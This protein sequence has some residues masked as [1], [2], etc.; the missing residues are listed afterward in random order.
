[1]VAT[2]CM[3]DQNWQSAVNLLSTIAGSS[4]ASAGMP[5]GSLADL[6]KLSGP[7]AGRKGGKCVGFCG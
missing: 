4:V 5:N 7:V 3:M 2:T 1:M 6:P